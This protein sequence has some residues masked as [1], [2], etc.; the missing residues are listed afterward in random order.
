MGDVSFAADERA[1]WRLRLPFVREAVLCTGI[2]TITAS[3]LVWLGP[4]GGDLAAHEYQRYAVPA[5]RLH[6]LGQLLVRG[7]LRVRRLQRPLLPARRAARDRAALGALRRA[8]RRRVRAPAR[9]GVGSRRA[10]GEPLLRGL[11]AGSDPGRRA[12]VRARSR[13]RAALPARA[14]GRTALDGRGAD[15]PHARREPRRVRPARRRA[16]RDRVGRHPGLRL[17]AAAVPAVAVARRGGGRAGHA[18]SVSGG[19]ARVPGGRGGR[20]QSPSASSGS[21]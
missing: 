21:R 13:A 2:A 3:L 12:S 11:L 17:R 14:A 1:S 19:H 4:R 6:A 10:L 18:A 20:R 7:P 16:G 5:A 8:R 9:T 15:P